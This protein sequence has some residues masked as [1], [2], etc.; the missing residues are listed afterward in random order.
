[1]VLCFIYVSVEI[2]RYFAEHFFQETLLLDG[3]GASF[4][5]RYIASILFIVMAHGK[6]AYFRGI[7]LKTPLQDKC[8]LVRMYVVKNGLAYI[9]YDR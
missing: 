7:H 3:I 2:K 9:A 1:M 6:I 4:I 8:E 5:G